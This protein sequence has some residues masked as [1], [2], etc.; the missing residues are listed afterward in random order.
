MAGLWSSFVHWRQNWDSNQSHSYLVHLHFAPYNGFAYC[1]LYDPCLFDEFKKVCYCK[2]KK[3]DLV[4]IGF[5]F[6]FGSFDPG[7]STTI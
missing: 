6:E 3:S 2:K 7:S 1:Y 5:G 4:F